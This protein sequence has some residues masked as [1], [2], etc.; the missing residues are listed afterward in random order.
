MYRELVKGAVK[1]TVAELRVKTA[2]LAEHR[3]QDRGRAGGA[4]EDPVVQAT[5][6]RD[7]RLRELADQ[8]HGVNLDLGQ[9]LLSGLS[10]VDPSS[11]EVVIWRRR[12]ASSTSLNLPSR[13]HSR[14]YLPFVFRVVHVIGPEAGGSRS[15]HH[16]CRVGGGCLSRWIGAGLPASPTSR[17]G[18]SRKR[19]RG[20]RST[21]GLGSPEPFSGDRQRQR[22]KLELWPE[23]MRDPAM[24]PPTLRA[25][26]SRLE[27]TYTGYSIGCAAVWAALLATG[28]G[29]L[30]AKNWDM[31][32]LGA[33]GWWAGW[34]SATIARVGYPP[35]R[36]LTEAGQRRLE[37]VSLVLDDVWAD[38][39]AAGRD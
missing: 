12:G 3:K 2:E 24:T 38:R 27:N 19:R 30:D 36:K 37:K 7:R 34:L 11:L 10:S 6:E 35:P 18:R 14:R 33:A 26:R 20:R 32:R 15:I 9:G 17:G 13:C 39:A 22:R 16:S 4:P 29:L 31:L 21:G 5:R 28:R 23:W 1:R 8:A 25:I